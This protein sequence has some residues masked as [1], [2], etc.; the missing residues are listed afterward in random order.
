MSRPTLAHLLDDFGV[1]QPAD[2]HRLAAGSQRAFVSRLSTY[3]LEEFE[4]Q[5]ADVSAAEGIRLHLALGE[6][7]RP[8]R[9]PSD[10]FLKKMALFADRTVITVR[11]TPRRAREGVPWGHEVP[12]ARGTGTAQRARALL[13]GRTRGRRTAA[14]GEVE[15]VARAYGVDAAEFD[16]LVALI[17]RCKPLLAAGVAH[18]VPWFPD[19]KRRL[20]SERRNWLPADFTSRD[21]LRQLDERDGS[22]LYGRAGETPG[23]AYLYLPHVQRLPMDDVL[24]LR[25]AEPHPFH[26]FQRHLRELLES[27]GAAASDD[28][29]R[30]ALREVDAGV[31]QLDERIRQARR[32]VRWEAYERVRDIGTLTPR[33]LMKLAPT[34]VGLVAAGPLGWLNAIAGL[35]DAGDPVLKFIRFVAE[36]RSTLADAGENS[37]FFVPWQVAGLEREHARGIHVLAGA[38]E[39]ASHGTVDHWRSLGTTASRERL[40]E[41]LM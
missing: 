37:D 16:D 30:A 18:V 14:G 23:V 17:C 4:P 3:C 9:M 22:D 40:F 34:L 36:E 2:Y 39:Q 25:F 33:A 27:R 13:F 6:H 11:F 28:F 32:K 1:S 5:L 26:R 21:V 8:V 7:G 41:K 24:D 38:G 29:I 12:E 19:Q 31:Q 10:T 15:R 20:K 35:F